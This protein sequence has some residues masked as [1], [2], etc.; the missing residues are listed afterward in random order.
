MGQ[1]VNKSAIGKKQ[2]SAPSGTGTE[3]GRPSLRSGYVANLANVAQRTLQPPTHLNASDILYLQRTAG[4]HA[5]RNLL[6]RKTRDEE[7]GEASIGP[8]GGEVDGKTALAIQRAK[9]GGR[10]VPKQV[11]A[12][13]QSQIGVDVGHARIHTGKRAENLNRKLNAEA[14]TH[15]RDIFFN[16]GAY[17]PGTASG[18]QL[19]AHE[20]THVAQQTA[21]QA[22]RNSNV[23]QRRLKFKPE[24]LDGEVS[25]RG[26]RA[27]KFGF[28]STFSKIQRY[29]TDY[30]DA[31]D[32]LQ[33]QAVLLAKMDVE[34]KKWT[35]RFNRKEHFDSN[36]GLKSMSL[37]KLKSAIDVELPKVKDKIASVDFMKKY[38]YGS[39]YSQGMSISGI[40]DPLSLGKQMK[41]MEKHN[42]PMP[43]NPND[44]R[45]PDGKG[46]EKGTLTP[47]SQWDD[48]GK[49]Y[50]QEKSYGLTPA[51]RA[52]LQSYTGDQY[53][54][55]N[56]AM[57][58]NQGWFQGT[59]NEKLGAQDERTN[60]KKWRKKAMAQN[61]EIGNMLVSTLHK[62]PNWKQDKT[63]YRGETI[64]ED[65]AQQVHAGVVKTFP[66]FVSTS[67]ALSTPLSQLG[68]FKSPARPWGIVY[69]IKESKTGKDVAPWS[70]SPGEAEILFAPNTKFLVTKVL[71]R[72]DAKKMIEV[73][74]RQV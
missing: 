64:P 32:D 23:V 1:P 69:H 15:G 28:E 46:G 45:I 35:Q 55:M 65:E 38:T 25:K 5:V 72:D 30:W 12:E 13:L 63:I 34:I 10:T 73:E 56:P 14:F 21:P 71:E 70:N 3:R 42:I 43:A 58:N 62:L 9:S 49:R 54:W 6:A 31:G 57:A 36:H 61:K 16:K 66:I 59:M 50:K 53:R 33:L 26:K 20:L 47:Q 2:N 24:D 40:D 52:A 22:G 44:L 8:Q 11:A 41:H 17:Q 37:A 27:G 48:L 18:K 51:N 68:S 7:R 19:L 60:D 39:D 67:Q 29:L 74:V 4:N